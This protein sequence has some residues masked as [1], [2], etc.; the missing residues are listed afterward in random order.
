ML[1][2]KINSMRNQHILNV[3]LL[4]K[5]TL[6]NINKIPKVKEVKFLV[7]LNEFSNSI[8]FS[9]E[10]FQIYSFFIMYSFGFMFPSV[11]MNNSLNTPFGGKSFNLKSSLKNQADIE[12][13][14]EYMLLYLIEKEDDN[15]KVKITKSESN[16][17]LFIP[18][19]KN[20]SI[21]LNQKPSVSINI[22]F[23]FNKKAIKKSS[24]IIQFPPFWVLKL[25]G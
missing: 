23:K 18:L 8:S 17:D 20:L 12:I 24:F 11:Q 25:N 1:K 5:Y 4:Q 2:K 10:I 22:S 6:Q 15:Q 16:I 3:D 21:D 9:E 7:N 14:L 19:T 13:F